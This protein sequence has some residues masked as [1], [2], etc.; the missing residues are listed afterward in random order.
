M[1]LRFGLLIGLLGMTMA[2]GSSYSSPSP[3]A[4]TPPP[5]TGTGTGVT[6]VQGASSLSANAY[7]PNPLTVAPGTTIT[8]T[9]NDRV[10][11]TSSGDDGSWNSGDIAPGG[12]F[13]RTFA[14]AGSFKYHCAIHPG[15]VGTVVVQ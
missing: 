11:H 15:M 12:N 2:C 5:T 3:S 13:S 4:P 1:K 14:T 7:A 8:W 10:A 6:I 9:N